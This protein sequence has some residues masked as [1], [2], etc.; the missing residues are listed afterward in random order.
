MERARGTYYYAFSSGCCNTFAR[1]TF[2]LTSWK[3]A[4]ESLRR[5]NKAQKSTF[6]LFGTSKSSR[7]DKNRDDE[8]IRTQLIIDVN[9]FSQDAQSLGVDVESCSSFIAL[10]DLVHASL[11]DGSSDT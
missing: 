5:I 7:D 4:E 6:S 11:V 8:R 3:K 9:A 2:Y 1:Y 10:R